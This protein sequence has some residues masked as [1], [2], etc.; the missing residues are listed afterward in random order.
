MDMN[1][2]ISGNALLAARVT[3]PAHVVYRAFVAETVVL[4]L[5]TGKYHGL[6]PI[7]GR[8]IAALEKSATVREAAASIATEYEQPVDAVAADVCEFCR[9]LHSRGLIEVQLP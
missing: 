8:M 2:T 5:E 1:Q 9:D 4:N 6:N 7:G 3:V